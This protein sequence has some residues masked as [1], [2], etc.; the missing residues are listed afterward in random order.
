MGPIPMKLALEPSP[1]IEISLRVN[2]SAFAVDQTVGKFSFIQT[3]IMVD[4]FALSMWKGIH[5][6][7]SVTA[8]VWVS[9]WPPGGEHVVLG[10]YNKFLGEFAKFV[11]NLL[12]KW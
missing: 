3:S 4:Y 7:A 9:V 10:S 8:A 2:F 5:K 6:L 1:I 11:Q 12:D